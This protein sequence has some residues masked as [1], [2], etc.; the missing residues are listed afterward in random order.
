MQ[1]ISIIGNVGKDAEFKTINNR[2]YI[3]LTVGENEGRDQQTT[4]YNI[5]YRTESDKLCQWLKKGAKLFIEGRLSAKVYN[6]ASNGPKVDLSILARD[7]AIVQFAKDGEQTGNA[8]PA[9]APS[10]PYIKPQQGAELEPES[11]P[12][13]LPF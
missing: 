10:N 4:W 2:S 6:S 5:L 3:T 11:N 8:A 7:I 9:A 13:D 1:K 12:D